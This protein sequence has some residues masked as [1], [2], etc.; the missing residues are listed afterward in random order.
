MIFENTHLDFLANIY[1]NDDNEYY[2]L[3]YIQII[4]DNLYEKLL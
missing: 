1:K 3:P 2:H 4:I